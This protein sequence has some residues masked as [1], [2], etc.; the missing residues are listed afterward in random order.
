M[1]PKEAT[2][3]TPIPVDVPVLSVQLWVLMFKAKC[4]SFDEN[5]LGTFGLRFRLAG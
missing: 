1:R 5:S 4:A 3:L 2:H